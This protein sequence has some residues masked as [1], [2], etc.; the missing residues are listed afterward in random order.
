MNGISKFCGFQAIHFGRTLV[1]SF[2]LL[3]LVLGSQGCGRMKMVKYI[4]G[5][6]VKRRAIRMKV[7]FYEVL[8]SYIIY[9][10]LFYLLL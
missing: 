6:K 9:C 10:L 2:N 5:K 3:P 7:D 1:V 8:I 4:I